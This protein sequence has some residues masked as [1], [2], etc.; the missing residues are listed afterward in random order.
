MKSI[1]A[2]FASKAGASDHPFTD[3][4]QQTAAGP[5]YASLLA[6]AVLGLR[7]APA[8]LTSASNRL[9]YDDSALAP[10]AQLTCTQMLPYDRQR[11]VK[12]ACYGPVLAVDDSEPAHQRRFYRK[13]KQLP[14]I[15]LFRY[16]N[17]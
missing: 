4:R 17:T 1:P 11:G 9:C 12:R 15:N 10:C 14:R 5:P 13:L 8:L 3:R 7:A 6:P 2:Q 16:G